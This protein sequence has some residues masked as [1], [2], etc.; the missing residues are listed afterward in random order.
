MKGFRL[1]FNNQKTDAAIDHGVVSLQFT[2]VK[3]QENDL[4]SLRLGGRDEK[5]SRE[6]IW[7]FEELRL[8]EEFTVEVIDTIESS[9][10]KSSS[11]IDDEE[12]LLENNLRTY[13]HLKKELEE[14][15]HL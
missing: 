5:K 3:N 4:I 11:K 1:I 10:P 7:I 2:R 14:A 6:V 12:L 8:G 9:E 15:G 13:K